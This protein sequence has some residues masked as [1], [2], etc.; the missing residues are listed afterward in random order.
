M[1]E[2][3]LEELPCN[4]CCRYDVDGVDDWIMWCIV[5]PKACN[6]KGPNDCPN[7]NRPNGHNHHHTGTNRPRHN[8][9]ER[10]WYDWTDSRSGPHSI[11]SSIRYHCRECR[12]S[13]RYDS[14]RS[15]GVGWFNMPTASDGLDEMVRVGH[16]RFVVGIHHS[17]VEVLMNWTNERRRTATH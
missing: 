16:F 4:P 17:S 2:N 1:D 15:N 12:M 5:A 10:R 6:C 8:R 7:A 9:D 13:V 11:G 14:R 3:E